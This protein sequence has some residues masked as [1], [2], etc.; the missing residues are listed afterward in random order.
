MLQYRLLLTG[1]ALATESDLRP[2]GSLCVCVCVCGHSDFYQQTIA[3]AASPPP[4]THI[5][6]HT[7]THVNAHS[8]RVRAPFLPTWIQTITVT[9]K[10]KQRAALRLY[11]HARAHT[12]PRRAPLRTAWETGA[13]TRTSTERRRWH[14]GTDSGAEV[15]ARVSRQ[16][17]RGTCTTGR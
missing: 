17:V 1:G 13:F 16:R 3:L 15:R 6:T 12:Q 14:G 7:S 5:H 8:S 2:A 4:H 9:E 11:A 10:T